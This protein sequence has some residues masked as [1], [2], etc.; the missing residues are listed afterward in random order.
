MDPRYSGHEVGIYNI[1][2]HKKYIYNQTKQNHSVNSSPS[3]QLDKQ[4]P[5]SANIFAITF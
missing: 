1:Q 4:H 2:E 3:I 5:K